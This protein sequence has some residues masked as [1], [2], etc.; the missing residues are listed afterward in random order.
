MNTLTEKLQRSWQLFQSSVRVILE[1]PKLLIFP[2]VTGVLTSAIALF[3]LAPVVL[4]LLAP[5]WVS[6]TSIQAIADRV[7]FLRFSNGAT[8]NFNIQPIGTTILAGIYLMNMFL[9]TM[10][11][12]AFNAEIMEALN[13]HPV[14]IQRGIATACR[15][16]RPILLW[17]L[18][19]GIVGLIIRAL[20]ERWALV[21]RAIAGLIGLAWSMASIFAIPILARDTSVT[22]PFTILSKSATTIKRT[23]G[24]M[25]AGYVG[26]KGMN[27]LVVWASIFS[28]IGVGVGAYLLSNPWI[29][30]MFGVPWL[31][32]VIVYSYL[33]SIAS[34]V[35]LCALYLYASA[36]Q[37]PAQYDA[38]M[39]A[40][41]WKLK[42]ADK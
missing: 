40:M 15:R 22:N 36:G 41:G 25:L 28:W 29:L 1:Q 11:S 14:S 4:V 20:E 19:A 5:H 39:M 7:G 3:F 6:G 35:Y 32:S 2:I 42:R 12:V 33:T 16:W 31:G 18:V 27:L 23:W 38:S 17:S 10:A 30:L 34:R 8:F 9:A 37:I 26:M 24:E 13:G 21:G